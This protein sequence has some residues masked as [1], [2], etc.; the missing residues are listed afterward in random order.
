M[1]GS[2]GRTRGRKPRI[3]PGS[4]RPGPD[5][6]AKRNDR[7]VPARPGDRPPA[8][9]LCVRPFLPR[10]RVRRARREPRAAGRILP[11]PAHGRARPPRDARGSPRPFSAPSTSWARWRCGCR[12]RRARRIAS[13]PGYGRGGWH[14]VAL[15]DRRAQRHGV[16]RGARHR[17]GAARGGA[18]V[19]GTGRRTHTVA[20]ELHVAL[21]FANM[22]GASVFGIASGSTGYSAGSPGRP[23]RPPSRTPTWRRSAGP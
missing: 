23:C 9:L 8:P 22:L 10:A 7:R 13:L 15:L 18:S 3:D 11:P 21:A 19:D 2:S 4:A 20:R 5:D 17:G 12:C 14:G 6:R 1:T 16:V